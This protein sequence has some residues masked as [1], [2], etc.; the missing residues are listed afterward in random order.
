M[1]P[2]PTPERPGYEPPARIAELPS[3]LVN[4]A[5][6]RANALVAQALAAEAMR[7]HHY[8]VMTALAERGAASQAELGRRLSLDRSD[9]HAILA[10][11][12]AGALVAR[13]QDEN[14]KRR[15]LVELT[16]AGARRLRK[17]DAAIASAQR[18]LLAPLAA[19]ERRELVRLLAKLAAAPGQG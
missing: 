9:T 15:N 8:T 14:D 2:D 10:E 16:P 18:E 4:E 11:L 13:A 12:E 6:R 17:L 3:W 1:S 5:A 7:R 19:G